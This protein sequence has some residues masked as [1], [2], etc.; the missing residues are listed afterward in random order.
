MWIPL[1]NFSTSEY[2]FNQ[3]VNHLDGDMALAFARERYSFTSRRQSERQEPGDPFDCF[4]PESP[5]PCYS[6]KYGKSYRHPEQQRRDQHEPGTDDGFD[7]PTAGGGK[8]VDYRIYSCHRGGR[9]PG[10]LFLRE[11]APCM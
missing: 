10:L 9:Y 7:Q 8:P 6:A 4:D 5:E 2:H 1:M 11:P 3:G